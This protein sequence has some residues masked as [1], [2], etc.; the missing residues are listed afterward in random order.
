MPQ[1]A[2]DTHAFRGASSNAAIQRGAVGVIEAHICSGVGIDDPGIVSADL[3][4]SRGGLG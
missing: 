4:M 2:A 1:M 3:S